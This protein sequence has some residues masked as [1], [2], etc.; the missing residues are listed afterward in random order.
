VYL[1]KILPLL[2][3]GFLNAAPPAPAPLSPAQAAVV[4]QGMARAISFGARNFSKANVF[5]ACNVTGVN[6]D[7]APL[8][9]NEFLALPEARREGALHPDTACLLVL[10]I[11]L[12]AARENPEAAKGTDWMVPI[13]VRVQAKGDAGALP[14]RAPV[15]LNTHTGQTAPSADPFPV[16]PVDPALGGE[17]SEAVG[18]RQDVDK[19]AGVPRGGNLGP[20]WPLLVFRRNLPGRDV[21]AGLDLGT[22][23]VGPDAGTRL[24]TLRH[25]QGPRRAEPDYFYA[26]DANSRAI[27]ENWVLA[28][29]LVARAEGNWDP[30]PARRQF[31][32]LAS[33]RIPAWDTV[34]A[35]RLKKAGEIVGGGAR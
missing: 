18:D 28:R 27:L 14:Y 22:G 6:E 23:M 11:G 17:R 2:A 8:F 7:A 20:N 34:L 9:P 33:T 16:L 30:L 35:A 19:A 24:W 4:I 32:E 13:L 10:R 26:G 3:A 31:L 25:N 12:A 5:A 15:T 21:R 1:V 29:I